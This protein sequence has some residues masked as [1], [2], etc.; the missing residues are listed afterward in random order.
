MQELIERIKQELITEILQQIAAREPP[1]KAV[2]DAK[3]TAE[4]IGYSIA[5][6]RQNKDKLPPPLDG[7][8][9][10]YLKTDLDE[11]L[12]SQKRPEQPIQP[13]KIKGISKRQAYTPKHMRKEQTQ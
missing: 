4:Y 8:K 7:D 5:W 12:H 11:W 1:Q 3:E 6:V 2:L 13:H 9:I 10:R